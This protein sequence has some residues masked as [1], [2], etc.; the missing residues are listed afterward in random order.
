MSFNPVFAFAS[1]S[2]SLLL[3]VT[4]PHPAPHLSASQAVIPAPSACTSPL[5]TLTQLP[6]TSPN[7]ILSKTVLELLKFSHPDSAFWSEVNQTQRYP[8]LCI[9]WS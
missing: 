9:N 6:E 5:S 4:L 7:Q 8:V 1:G 3:P 2:T